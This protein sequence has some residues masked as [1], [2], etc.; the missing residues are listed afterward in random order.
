MGWYHGG[1]W[2]WGGW[3][4]MVLAMA[5]VWGA[6]IAAIVV[7]FRSDA[8]G[9]GGRRTPRHPEEILRERFARGEIDETEYRLRSD[10]LHER[11]VD[12]TAAPPR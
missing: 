5:L 11:P 4:L 7:L 10:I 2:G 6:V 9:A 1:T 8:A 12:E 3:I